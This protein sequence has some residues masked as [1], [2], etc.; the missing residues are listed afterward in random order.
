MFVF[1]KIWHALFSQNTRFEIR[2][3]ALLLTKLAIIST[4]YT[5]IVWKAIH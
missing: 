2:P 4:T 3:F 5:C 1:R